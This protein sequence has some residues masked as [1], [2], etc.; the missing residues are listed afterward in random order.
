LNKNLKEILNKIKICSKIK[1]I[2]GLVLTNPVK[3]K[4]D[5]KNAKR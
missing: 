2:G 5:R 4:G 1:N 3:N